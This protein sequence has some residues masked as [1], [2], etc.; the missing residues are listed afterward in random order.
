MNS[1]PEQTTQ[2][3]IVN[4]SE[5]HDIK[6]DNIDSKDPDT[7]NSDPDDETYS[8]S[9]G[10]DDHDFSEDRMSYEEFASHFAQQQRAAADIARLARQQERKVQMEQLEA[11]RKAESDAR[12]QR[13]EERRKYMAQQ[14]QQVNDNM[15]ER[16]KQRTETSMK[17]QEHETAETI[18]REEAKQATKKIANI[19]YTI[20]E[21]KDVDRICQTFEIFALI[22][23]IV[24]LSWKALG[25]I[26]E[27]R[28]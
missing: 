9:T 2:D 5:R 26:A 14:R 21:S 7:Y 25:C 8:N 16:I 18:K 11:K 17:L 23:G 24:L 19:S 1:S 6:E 22:G 13:I 3:N 27:H 10:N 15:S 20:T 28:L 4:P 12:E